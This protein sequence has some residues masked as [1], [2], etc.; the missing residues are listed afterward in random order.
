MKKRHLKPKDLKEAAKVLHPVV[1][2]KLRKMMMLE[3]AGRRRWRED[4][5][6]RKVK[7]KV[8]IAPCH[9]SAEPVYQTVSLPR[10]RF[11]EAKHEA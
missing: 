8:L 7:R 1:V 2:R 4:K 3:Q 5:V 11:L 10:L 6:I 9:S